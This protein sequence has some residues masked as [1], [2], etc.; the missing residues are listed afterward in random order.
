MKENDIREDMNGIKFEILRDDEERKKDQ[1]KRLQ[2]YVEAIQK[3]VSIHT[4]EVVK[5]LVAERHRQGLT[6]SDIADRTG[7]KASNIARLENGS[8][9]PTLVVLEKYASALGKHIEVKIL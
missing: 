5:E 2:A 6:Q 9:I 7:M 8:G 3:K 4:D 1:L